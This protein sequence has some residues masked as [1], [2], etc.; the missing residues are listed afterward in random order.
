L[1]PPRSSLHTAYH[2]KKIHTFTYLYLLPEFIRKSRHLYCLHLRQV[3]QST[4]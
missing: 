4:P 2:D 1:A 3:H